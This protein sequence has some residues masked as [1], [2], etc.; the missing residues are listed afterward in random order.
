MRASLHKLGGIF[1]YFAEHQLYLMG[2]AASDL[3]LTVVVD[4]AIADALVKKL[5]SKLIGGFGDLSTFGTPWNALSQTEEQ[6]VKKWWH[7]QVQTL[8]K[9][10]EVQSPHI[11][12][13][14]CQPSK[15]VSQN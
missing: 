6:P 13:T 1:E 7:G 9:N 14:I 15:I 4:E 10:W 3:N 5:H 2:Q 11:T 12:S 8:T